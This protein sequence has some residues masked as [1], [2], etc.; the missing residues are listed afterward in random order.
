MSYES[1][2]LFWESG[3][4]VDEIEHRK[5]S[6][7]YEFYIAVARGDVTAVKKN[8]DQ[9]KFIE[10]EGVGVL[11]KDPVKNL[12]YHY[13]ITTAMVTRMCKQHGMELEQAFRLS[14]FYIQKLDYINTVEEVA[15]LHDEMVMD[16]TKKMRKYIANNMNSKHID[17][18]KNY[19]YNHMKERITLEDVAQEIGVSQGYLSRLFKKE[20]GISISAYIRQQK[21]EMAENLLQFSNYSLS[22]IA[23]R[24][25]FASQSHFIQQFREVTGMTPKKYRDLYFKTQWDLNQE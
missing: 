4:D 2:W 22:D 24:L 17:M 25:A 3:D 19:I 9:K 16:F 18:S 1:E 15:Q 10:Q 8:C 13:V 23:H 12:K 5:L 7:E 6:E 20:M 11:S 14:D 21:I